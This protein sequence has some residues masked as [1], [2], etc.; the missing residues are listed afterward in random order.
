MYRGLWNEKGQTELC[1]AKTIFESNF[2]KV[3]SNPLQFLV[4]LLLVL[5]GSTIL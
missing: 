2:F 3:K 5:T 1:I 4:V